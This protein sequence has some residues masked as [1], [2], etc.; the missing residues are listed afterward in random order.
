MFWEI[1]LNKNISKSIH[2]WFVYINH[3]F[4]TYLQKTNSYICPFSNRIGS[5]PLAFRSVAATPLKQALAVGRN[6]GG[7]A[8]LNSLVNLQLPPS[9]DNQVNTVNLQQG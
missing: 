6:G 2:I 3:N 1:K 9:T 4:T 7:P 5:W 8:G